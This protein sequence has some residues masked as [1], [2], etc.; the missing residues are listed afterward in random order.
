MNDSHSV[1]ASAAAELAAA[2]HRA[3]IIHEVARGLAPEDF[4]PEGLGSAADAERVLA[5]WAVLHG[6]RDI[7][8]Q[9]ALAAGV[10]KIRAHEITRLSRSTIDRNIRPLPHRLVMALPADDFELRTTLSDD[11]DAAVYE[12]IDRRTNQTVWGY[13]FA[14]GDRKGVGY[15][16]GNAVSAT[17]G[18]EE[19]WEVDRL[20]QAIERWPSFGLDECRVCGK[21][22][23]HHRKPLILRA[24]YDESDPGRRRLMEHIVIACF[25][26]SAP[27]SAP[28]EG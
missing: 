4:A 25:E 13:R 9:E 22:I 26:D 16:Y 27:E 19:V 1:I 6:Q 5:G 20:Q 14:I 12:L 2:T 17:H 23:E 18:P 8:V 10:S 11:G 7:F 3:R 24:A 28:V 21:A 15:H